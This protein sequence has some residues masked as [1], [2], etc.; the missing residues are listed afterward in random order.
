MKKHVVLLAA[1]LTAV[2][3]WAQG[4][5]Q[6]AEEAV[7]TTAESAAEETTEEVSEEETTEAET[8]EEAAEEA[9]EEASEVADEVSATGIPAEYEPYLSWTSE[10][11]NAASDEEKTE[12]L[13]AYVLY[14]GIVYQGVTD[15]TADDVKNEPEFESLRGVLENSITSLPDTSL[16]E[17]CDMGHSTVS[18]ADVELDESIVQ[19][20]QCTAEDWNAGTDDDRMEIAK[21]MVVAVGKMAGQEVTMDQ[22]EGEEVADA[23]NQQ[24]AGIQALFD[25]GLYGDETL[26][27]I[28][29][30]VQ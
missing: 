5:S 7:E 25:S 10:D 29:G 18:L 13:I 3:L 19:L 1:A 16:Q 27:D 24:V 22:L 21:A 9:E 28:I 8:T 4:C 11:Y 15:L 30:S 12:A 26:Y 2:S 6:P 14:D 17:I 20:L 23:M